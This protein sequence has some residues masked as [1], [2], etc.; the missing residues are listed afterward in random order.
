MIHRFDKKQKEDPDKKATI[1]TNRVV[2]SRK[3]VGFL[4]S[5]KVKGIYLT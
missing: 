2:F 5:S 4:V 1:R 3:D